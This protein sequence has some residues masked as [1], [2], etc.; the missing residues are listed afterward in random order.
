MYTNRYYVSTR[1]WDN[2]RTV[3]GVFSIVFV[4]TDHWDNDSYYKGNFDSTRRWDNVRAILGGFLII[5]DCTF[6]VFKHEY[7]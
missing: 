5:V 2:V 1:R 3:L 7:L 6:L 4:S